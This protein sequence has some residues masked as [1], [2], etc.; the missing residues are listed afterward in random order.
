MYLVDI[1]TKY[2]F[3]GTQF[4]YLTLH[5][6][7]TKAPDCIFSRQL[8]ARPLV[9]NTK[10]ISYHLRSLNMLRVFY[11]VRGIT[12]IFKS[13]VPNSYFKPKSRTQIFRIISII[14]PQINGCQKACFQTKGCH[15]I[16]GTRANDDPAKCYKNI[17]LMAYI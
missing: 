1:R 9:G 6:M 17:Y 5:K 3:I 8:L 7:T 14:F 16:Y 2:Q 13:R 12:R 10:S 4:F 15:G 11:S